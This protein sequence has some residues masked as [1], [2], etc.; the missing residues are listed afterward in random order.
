MRTLL[1]PFLGGPSLAAVLKLEGRLREVAADLV[2]DELQVFGS[3]LA[4]GEV[5]DV[6]ESELIL[7]P[8]LK[9]AVSSLLDRFGREVEGTDPRKQSWSRGLLLMGRP[10]TGKTLTIAHMLGR[11]ADCRRYLF[12][13]AA[14]AKLNTPGRRLKDLVQSIGSASRPSWS[15]RI[16]TGCFRPGP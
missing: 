7:S 1:E 3:R 10:G 9:E 11:L 12:V 15:S 6:P 4:L 13:P 2:T 16:S 14:V 5:P 8:D